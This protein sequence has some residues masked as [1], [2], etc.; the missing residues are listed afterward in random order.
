MPARIQHIAITCAENEALA[1]FYKSTFGLTEV[2]RHSPEGRPDLVGI[3]LTDGHIN[4]ALLPN[5]GGRPEGINHFGILVEDLE[6]ARD[7]ALANGAKPAAGALPKDGR[8]AEDYV[9]D[10]SGTRVDLSDKGWDIGRGRP[11]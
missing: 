7:R 2:F 5:G 1:E 10:P 11:S 8:Y 6:A 3:Y 4:L 9:I